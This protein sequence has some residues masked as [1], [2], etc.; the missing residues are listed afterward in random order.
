M[1]AQLPA[2]ARPLMLPAVAVG[3]YLQALQRHDFNVF[4]PRLQKD[5][6]FSPLWHQVLTKY[7]LVTNA[8]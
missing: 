4:A 3:L 5:G 2:H 7:K 8:F 1:S 6:G